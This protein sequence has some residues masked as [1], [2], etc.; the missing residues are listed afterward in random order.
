M[1]P[2]TQRIGAKRNSL[3][4]RSLELSV[5]C[6]D[7]GE[8]GQVQDRRV[9][10]PRKQ[11]RKARRVPEI[12]EKVLVRFAPTGCHAGASQR[13][14]PGSGFVRSAIPWLSDLW[15][16]ACSVLA[17]ANRARSR[18]VVSGHNASIN[19]KPAEFQRSPRRF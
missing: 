8:Q 17:L 9:W 2:A 16:S 4:Q 1:N 15:N 13:T 14:K 5:L 19:A 7:V 18:T 10:P 12:A 3:A 11:Q 6:V